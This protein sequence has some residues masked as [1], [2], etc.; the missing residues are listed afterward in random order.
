[1]G[2]AG[3]C[4]SKA[5]LALADEGKLSIDDPV[6]RWIPSFGKREA[7]KITIR[8]LL[9][10][11]SGLRIG[12]LFLQPLMEKSAEHPDAPNLVLEA[13]RFGEVGPEAEP[14]K[15]YAYSNPGY[16]TLAAIVEIVSGEGFEPFCR[17]RFYLPLGMSETCNHE[18]RADPARMST[19]VRRTDAGKWV[20]RWTPGNPPTVPFVRGSGGLISTATDFCRFC[21]LW[22]DDGTYGNRSILSPKSVRAATSLQT[23]GIEGARYGFG[24]RID[25]EGQFSHGGSDGTWVWCDRR[26]DVIG[27]VLTQTQGSKALKKARKRFRNLVSAACPPQK[28][29]R[30]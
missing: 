3:R 14:G 2:S 1:V 23:K 27:M 25:E 13:A 19:V 21:R 10:H 6:S 29:R 16:N 20:V 18:S 9:T 5:A 12:S 7:T 22:L 8:H 26:R 17:R 11:T 15:T 30:E 24:W 4:S 28:A